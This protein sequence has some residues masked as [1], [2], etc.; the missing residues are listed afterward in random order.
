MVA[1]LVEALGD[2][3]SQVRRKAADALGEIGVERVVPALM[4]AFQDNARDVR[5]EVVE[6]LDELHDIRAIRKR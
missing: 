5:R 1:A 2:E 3:A 4:A 6:S